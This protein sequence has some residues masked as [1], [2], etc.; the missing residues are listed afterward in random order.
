MVKASVETIGR[1]FN[2][3]LES[4]FAAVAPEPRVLRNSAKNPM[5]LFCFAAANEKGAKIALKIAN[6]LLAKG[7]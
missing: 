3:R 6:H 2:E 5:Y 7:R 4:V 1:Y